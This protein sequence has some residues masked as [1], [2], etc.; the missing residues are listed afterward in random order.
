MDE[1]ISKVKLSEPVE[2]F[3]G[4]IR[5][6][7]KS[8]LSMQTCVN[9]NPSLHLLG[10]GG[11]IATCNIEQG[12]SEVVFKVKD[13]QGILPVML[14]SGAALLLCSESAE[15]LVIIP[16]DGLPKVLH[17]G[18]DPVDIKGNKTCRIH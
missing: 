9:E 16:E 12:M 5:L 1:L 4:D 18:K 8:I 14:G 10:R 6:P 2:C 3:T 15:I 7:F 13:Y 11:H 17:K